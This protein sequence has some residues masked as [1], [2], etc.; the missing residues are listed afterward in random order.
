MLNP[1]PYF[2]ADY[3]GTKD[4]TLP[5]L[6]KF[7]LS[8]IQRLALDNPGQVFDALIQDLTAYY[9]ALFGS[10]TATD[11]GTSQRRSSA[12]QMWGALADLQHQLEEDEA[13]IDYKSKKT[14]ALRGAFFPNG[15][16][17]YANASLLT[18][19]K[20]F[21]RAQTAASAHAKTLGAEFD[22]ALYAGFYAAF[23]AGRD[24]TGAGD[25]QSAKARA[26]AQHHRD[27]L[28]HRLSDAV[29]LVA[30]RFLRDEARAAAYFVVGLLQAPTAAKAEKP[31]A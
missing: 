9:E 23:K 6:Q 13:L 14:P 3:F 16:T 2:A 29:K 4:V 31:A 25:E 11:A 1:T 22:P 21:E 5:R 19:D 28:T 30:A 15:R 17:E 7:A 8:V 26:A 24:G 18:A 27:D 10:V 20:L 12:Q